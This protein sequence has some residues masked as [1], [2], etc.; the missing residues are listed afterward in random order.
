MLVNKVLQLSP[1]TK[2]HGLHIRA[3]IIGQ[4]FK[5]NQIEV[6][7]L[8]IK[9]L[10]WANI[11][12]SYMKQIRAVLKDKYDL[13]FMH[14]ALPQN[15]VLAIIVRLR[16]KK[17]MVDI[18]DYEQG[19]HKQKILKLII[20]LSEWSLISLATF[21]T[22]HS[23]KIEQ[24]LKDT[25]K[26]KRIY[27]LPQAIDDIYF[28]KLKK[29]RIDALRSFLKLEDKRLCIY[30][31]SFTKGALADFDKVWELFEQ[32]KS[33]G[34]V[35]KFLL[36]GAGPQEIELRSFVEKKAYRKDVLWAGYI[37]NEKVAEYIDI[38]DIALV[39]MRESQDNLSRVSLKT[40]EYLARKKPV[41]GELVGETKRLV[42]KFV[43]SMGDSF[44]E[45]KQKEAYER[46]YQ[47]N[48]KQKLAL[49]L[50]TALLE[51]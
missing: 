29:E 44:C 25:F 6:R 32:Y 21:A 28:R 8:D 23:Q 45:A 36:L 15:I 24:Y 4:A 1:L 31:A 37:E 19:F 49:E 22:T 13:C 26:V 2:E 11:L 38:A 5:Q 20:K 30:V 27:R 33:N 34:F 51:L 7:F 40:L 43:Y 14:K 35:D 46:I 39:Y 3:K 9:S 18:D 47:E 41:V 48:S 50:K 12:S 17:L 10:D 42:G 16:G